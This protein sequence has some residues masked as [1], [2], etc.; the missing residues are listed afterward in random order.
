MY[1]VSSCHV[2]AQMDVFSRTTIFIAVLLDVGDNPGTHG[3]KLCL[4]NLVLW[5]CMAEYD[6]VHHNQHKRD[7]ALFSMKFLQMRVFG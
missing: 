7:V 4:D 5:D 6:I 3:R 2:T 1:W